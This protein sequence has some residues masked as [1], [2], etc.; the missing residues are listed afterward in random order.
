M[1]RI[2]PWFLILAVPA[3]S[4]ASVQVPVSQRGES[5]ISEHERSVWKTPKRAAEFQDVPH[6][7]AK[8]R[9]EDTRPPQALTTPNPL[10]VPADAGLMVKVSFIIGTDGRVHSPLI[11]QSSGPVGDRNVLRTVRTWR[12]RPATCNGV[13]TEAEGKIEFS[14]R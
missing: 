3:A 4:T 1:L 9:C 6:V 8:A 7:S 2:W 10:L 13:P 12:Y 5:V 14:R 11:L